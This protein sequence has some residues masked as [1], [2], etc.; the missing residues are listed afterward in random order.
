MNRPNKLE[1]FSLASLFGLVYYNVLAYWA[2]SQV[3]KKRKCCEYGYWSLN[4]KPVENQYVPQCKPL[5]G[6]LKE[7]KCSVRLTSLY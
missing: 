2:Y 5:Q 7:G 3:A 6:N 1:C 4:P